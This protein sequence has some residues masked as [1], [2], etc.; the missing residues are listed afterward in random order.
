[1]PYKR[2]NYK[3]K[4]RVSKAVK[5][6]VKQSQKSL[7]ETHYILQNTSLTPNYSSVNA[8]KLYDMNQGTNVDE[9]VG[10]KVEP[11]TL[12]FRFTA[13]RGN[14][15]A[16]LRLVVFRWTG[17]ATSS[18]I[19]STLVLE[20]S[21]AGLNGYVNAPFLLEKN[22]RKSFEVLHDSCY[23]LDDAKQN[24]IKK[25]INIKV[26]SRPIYYDT[27]SI[28]GVIKNPIQYFFIS[29]TNLTNAPTVEITTIQKYKDL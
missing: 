16:H 20:S 13:Y 21:L 1:M 29:D 25:V 9:R 4:P 10:L 5:K 7:G 24:G 27:G 26:N 3:R 22:A 12:Q 18:N 19:S 14:T 23:L 28:G 17:A 15:D 2:R 11:S 8:L 6:Y